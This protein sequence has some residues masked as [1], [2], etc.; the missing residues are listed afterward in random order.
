M[1]PAGRGHLP[2]P[3][4]KGEDQVE[5]NVE[6]FHEGAGKDLWEPAKP[7]YCCQCLRAYWDNT[8]WN[9]GE[10]GVTGLYPRKAVKSVDMG[11]VG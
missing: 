10:Y 6:G 2:V 1:N 11:Y 4:G 9:L 8:W 3:K 7:S 5:V